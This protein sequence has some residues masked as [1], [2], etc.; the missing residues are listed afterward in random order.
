MS[1]LLFRMRHVPEDEA[2]EVRELLEKHEIDYFE[3]F[4]GNWGISLPAIWLKNIEQFDFARQLLD[5]YQ[6]E[7]SLRLRKEYQLRR[8]KGEAKTGWHNFRESPLQFI[9]YSLAIVLVLY[10]STQFFLSF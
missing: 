8:E 3:T 9:V 7:R 6:Q 4:A 10:V 2:L 1:K 5:E